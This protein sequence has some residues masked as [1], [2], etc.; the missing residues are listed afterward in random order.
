MCVCVAA[1]QRGA[2]EGVVVDLDVAV[3]LACDGVV[4]DES[5][6]CNVVD[7]GCEA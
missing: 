1:W 3:R 5:S 4:E 6:L 2:K 7:D